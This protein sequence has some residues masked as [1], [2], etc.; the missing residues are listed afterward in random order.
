MAKKKKDDLIQILTERAGNYMGKGVNHENKEFK[1]N[2][3]LKPIIDNKGILL[4]YLAVG[5]E[6]TEFKK[7]STLYNVE[8]VLYNEEV[9][10]ICRDNNNEICLW[11]LNNNIGTLQKFELR[12]FR[13]VSKN[14]MIIIFGYGD[15]EDNQIF[16]EE[17]TVELWENGDLSY[18]YSWGESG[19]HY[20]SRS[21]VRMKKTS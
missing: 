16:R 1:G 5:T 12:R 19:G 6:G 11:T 13:H 20:I 14:R 2:L 8:T 15:K 10:L 9:T 21:T 4:K 7:D 18:N 3:E 17:I